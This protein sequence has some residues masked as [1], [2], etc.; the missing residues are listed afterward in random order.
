MHTAGS[1]VWSYS[2]PLPVLFKETGKGLCLWRWES[3][4]SCYASSGE[5]IESEE[6]LS[7]EMNRCRVQCLREVLHAERSNKPK[8]TKAIKNKSFI[9]F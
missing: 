7:N 4:S 6:L 1:V 5:S 8:L 3:K 9:N 2:I